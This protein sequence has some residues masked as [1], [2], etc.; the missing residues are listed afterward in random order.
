MLQ[1][2]LRPLEAS[3][4][5]HTARVLIVLT[6]HTI[7]V[8]AGQGGVKGRSGGAQSM[9]HGIELAPI[10]PFLGDR[11]RR[12]SVGLHQIFF[13][14]NL[15]SLTITNRAGRKIFKGMV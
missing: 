15:F 3:A 1:Q 10:L 6:P 11:P 7:A 13:P 5:F 8:P 12:L 2:Q 14:K 9:L 4:V